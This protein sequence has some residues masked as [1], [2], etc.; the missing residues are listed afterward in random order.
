MDIIRRLT[1]R[2]SGY[3]PQAAAV[4]G[5]VAAAAYLAEMAV[6]LP[7]FDCPTNDLLLLGGP[8]SQ[9]RRVW[10]LVGTAI[11]FTF[12]VTLAQAYS[13]AG[14]RLPGPPWLRGVTFTMIENTLLWGLVPLFD[15]FHPAIR[16]GNLPK[17]NRPIPFLQQVLRHIAYGAV[18]GVV[19]ERQARP[20]A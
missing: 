1:S 5:A 9:D 4:A 20:K 15:R 3:D 14:R 12:G 10:P 19:Y 13:V 7:L 6:D 11:H 8:I 18:L 17:M 2:E 16:S